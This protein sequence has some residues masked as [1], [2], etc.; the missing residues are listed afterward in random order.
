MEK[1]RKEQRELLNTMYVIENGVALLIS[2]TI[3]PV[4]LR[5]VLDTLW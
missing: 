3:V 1:D 5:T 2:L 4:F